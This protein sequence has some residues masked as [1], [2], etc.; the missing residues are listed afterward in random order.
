MASDLMNVGAT[1]KYY[2]VQPNGKAQSGLEVGDRVV[3]SGGTYQILD[4]NADG[5]YKSALYDE[6]ITTKNYGGKYENENNQYS[7]YSD[8][9]DSRTDA[10]SAYEEVKNSRPKEYKNQYKREIERLLDEIENREDFSYDLESDILYKQYRDSYMSAGKTAMEDVMGR[11][12]SLT[13]GY[14][15]TY[16]SSQASAAYES[17]IQK[18]NDKIPELYQNAR[19]AYEAEGDELY[20]LYSLYSDAERSDYAKYQNSIDEWQEERNAAYK[21]YVNETESIKDEKELDYDIYF[22][23]QEL[24]LDREKFEYEKVQDSL[25]TSSSSPSSSSKSGKSVTPTLYDEALIR[26][27]GGGETELMMYAEKL[28]GSGYSAEGV[29]DVVRY[30]KEYGTNSKRNSSEV[31]QSVTGSGDKTKFNSL[32]VDMFNFRG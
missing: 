27:K 11:T 10:Y 30:A 9:K 8:K 17:Y 19:N 20:R 5:S 6:N 13:G 14:G 2:K 7:S 25:K 1:G 31:V 26:Y 4:V 28:Y 3:T 23:E 29:K 16:A 12:S 24:A 18:L 21:E 22:K 32:L 15:S